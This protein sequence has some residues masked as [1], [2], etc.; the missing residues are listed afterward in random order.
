MLEQNHKSTVIF[1]LHLFHKEGTLNIKL[2]LNMRGQYEGTV[3]YW[4]TQKS[5]V[6]AMQSFEP[7]LKLL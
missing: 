2:F 6:T 5:N 7:E 4:V 3:P 1:Q